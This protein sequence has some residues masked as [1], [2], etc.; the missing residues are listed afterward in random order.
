MLKIFSLEQQK[1]YLR[2]PFKSG[3]RGFD[4]CDCGGLV[5][6]IYKHELGIELPDWTDLY[7]G[8]RIEN[9]LEL[10]ET[11]S[12][13]LGEHATEIEFKDRQPF[14][15]LSFRIGTD[16]IHVGLVLDKKYF[17]HTMQGFTRVVVERFASPQWADR[18]TGCY[19]HDSMFQK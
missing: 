10:A 12:T 19:R 7:S 9:S 18:I 16:P 3:C 15:V 5:W 6:L 4:G 1:K 11:V 13:V 2:I 14:D 17:M 8:T